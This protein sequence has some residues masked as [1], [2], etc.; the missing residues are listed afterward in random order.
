MSSDELFSDLVCNA[1]YKKAVEFQKDILKMDI[2]WLIYA[3]K[4]Q[5]KQLKLN[6]PNH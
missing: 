2:L 3:T 6:I 1:L 4:Y 5:Q